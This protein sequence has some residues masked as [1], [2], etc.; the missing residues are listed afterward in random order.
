MKKKSKKAMALVQLVEIILF[1]VAF[2]ILIFFSGKIALKISQDWKDNVC[3]FSVVWAGIL[4]KIPLYSVISDSPSLSC[5]KKVINFYPDHV[6]IDHKESSVRIGKRVTGKYKE[7]EFSEAVQ[8]IFA[9]Q[10]YRCWNKFG[11]G[12]IDVFSRTW[13]SGSNP[14]V[15]CADISFINPPSQR[16]TGLSNYLQNNKIT[17]H[18]IDKTYWE[19][20]GSMDIQNYFLFF[21]AGASW[22]SVSTTSEQAID[23]KKTYYIVFYAGKQSKAWGWLTGIGDYYYVHI[24]DIQSLQNYCTL[25]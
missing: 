21:P 16:V 3:K 7:S 13:F 22:K 23:T 20:L 24:Y 15:V 2:I 11:Q 4:N 6:E 8:Y 25:V 1:A 14:C 19:F 10:M 5:D 18:G 9:D 12:K 17:Q